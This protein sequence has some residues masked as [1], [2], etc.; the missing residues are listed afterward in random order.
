MPGRRFTEELVSGARFTE[1]PRAAMENVLARVPV[2]VDVADRGAPPPILLRGGDEV[3]PPVVLNR[4]VDEFVGRLIPLPRP[5][6]QRVI[7]QSV[8]ANT[9][10]AVGTAIDLVLVP[11]GDVNLGLLSG[12]HPDVATLA[13]T[14]L[15]PAV[16]EPQVRTLLQKTT[17][18]TTLTNDQKTVIATAFK[19]AA[20]NAPIVENDPTRNFAAVFRTLQSVRSFE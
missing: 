14:Q 17:D 4:Q 6:I 13:V 8:P 9:R 2:S 12:T 7:S 16:T 19:G 1:T 10:I 20:P 11:V 18:P 15:I 5:Q 3:V